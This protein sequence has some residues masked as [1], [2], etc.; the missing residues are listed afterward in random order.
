MFSKKFLSDCKYLLL[1]WSTQALS[2]LGSSMTGFALVLW[3]Y[4]Q[5]GSALTTALLTVCSYAP[6]VAVSIF[7]GALS[8]RWDKKRTMLACDALAALCTLGV[9][10]LWRWGGLRVWHLYLV[11]A[12]NGLMN[13]VQQPAS[14]VA[15]S[16]LTPREHYQ[17]VGG[18][19]AFSHSLVS[20]LAPVC[21]AALY[22]LGGLGAVIAL[23]LSTFVLA[24]ACLLVFIPIPRREAPGGEAEPVLRA[25][26]SGLRYLWEHRGVLDI[27]LFLAVINLTASM[28][29]AALPA[30][31]IPKAGERALGLVEGCA[32]AAGLLGGL[33][34]A[35]LPEPKSRVRVICDS[36]LFSMSTENF[37]LALG[38]GVPAWCVGAVLGWVFIPVMNANLDAL[39]RLHIP[40]EMQGRGYSA[41]NALQFF[42]SPVGY[43]L[44]GAL[45]DRGFEPF[46]AAQS[47]GGTL[48]TLFGTGKG[49]G[50]ALFFLVIG[51]FGALS[52]LPA[53][54]DRHIW[55]LEKE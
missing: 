25:A 48:C 47:P 5:Y 36:L 49:A 22:G 24:A 42:T 1:L 26:G 19:R 51:A 55:A 54:W 4:S 45:V 29:Q 6:Y 18:L 7:A 11:N 21:A 41:R 53:R 32:G 44:G 20:L 34:A 30:L 31:I 9:L 37:I 46:M 38:G 17:R 23:D 27:I 10:G 39:L 43:L 50:A 8:D 33:L 35:A 52:C 28:F 2:Q 16:L 15:V 12:L 13:T 40:V 14:D 3:S